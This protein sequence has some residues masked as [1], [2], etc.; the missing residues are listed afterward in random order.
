MILSRG[1]PHHRI[2]AALALADLRKAP[3][4]RL[5]NGQ[6]IAFLRFVTPNFQ[7]GKAGLGGGD[8][9]KVEV[10]AHAPILGQLGQGVGKPAGANVVNQ[11]NRIVVPQ[12]A[13][14]VDNFLTAALHLRVAPLH[15]GK[16]Q[17]FLARPGGHGG[18]SAASQA[19][20][21]GRPPKH[22]QGVPRR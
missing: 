13:A 12:G 7:G 19:D 11:R 1:P 20:E 16:V 4:R 14:P 6:N 5:G 22:H 21:H 3:E 17:R 15:G 18:G 2:G 9:A 8:S 10:P